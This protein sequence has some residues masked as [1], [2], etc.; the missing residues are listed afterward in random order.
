VNRAERLARRPVGLR[1]LQGFAE[2]MRRGSATAAGQALGLSQPGISRLIAQLERE[3]G[4][5]LFYRD[6]GRLIPTNDALQLAGEVELALA[7]VARVHSL[8]DDI[9]CF[10]TGEL[11][12]IAPPSFVE[13]IVPDIAAAFLK[14]L[15]RVRLSIDSRSIAT[16]KAMLATRVVDCA[17]I[18]LPIEHPE[19]VGETVVSS[20]SVCVLHEDNPLARHPLL[21]PALLSGAPFIMLGTGSAYGNELRQMFRDCGGSPYIVAESHTVS[22]ACALAARGI[23]VA[24]L[25]EL[26]AKT[27]LRAPL[28][29]RP[30]N[31]SIRHD[32]ALVTSARSAPSRLVE[33]FRSEVRT[34]FGNIS[35]IA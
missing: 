29:A 23:G 15:P 13:G 25:N 10:N 26:L 2:I 6:K 5:E 4:F 8:I 17:F 21:T 11:R 27:Y 7:G 9:G 19:L 12:L 1:A 32:Y 22:A 28:V 33:E 16:T 14:R 18:K 24:V 34:Y 31:P 20:G 35:S 30:F 3:I